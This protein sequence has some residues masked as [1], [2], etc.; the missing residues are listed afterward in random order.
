[1]P[2]I[3]HETLMLRQPFLKL[4]PRDQDLS[5][6]FDF[7]FLMSHSHNKNI[8]FSWTRGQARLQKQN[9]KVLVSEKNFSGADY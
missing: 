5:P 1:M 9:K 7:F 8:V 6:L 3:R 2:G 4:L